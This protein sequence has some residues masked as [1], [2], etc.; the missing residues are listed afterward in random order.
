MS[1]KEKIENKNKRSGLVEGYCLVDDY[2]EK[3][4]TKC[5]VMLLVFKNIFMSDMRYTSHKYFSFL[6]FV[7]YLVNICH[8]NKLCFGTKKPLF[9][10]FVCLFVCLISFSVYLFTSFSC[11]ILLIDIG[12]QKNA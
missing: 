5:T 1:I 3:K 12:F 8:N 9:V 10:L 11:L 4:I 6:F 2:G 7:V